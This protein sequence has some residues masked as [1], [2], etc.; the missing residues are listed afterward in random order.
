MYF[1]I[2]QDPEFELTS[3]QRVL[4]TAFSLNL[5]TLFLNYYNGN[6]FFTFVLFSL[7]L[8]ISLIYYFCGINENDNK[9]E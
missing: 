2:L 8:W 9:N 3:N 1:D 6:D 5:L 4:L 7:P